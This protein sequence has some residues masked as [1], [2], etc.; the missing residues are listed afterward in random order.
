MGKGKGNEVT[1]GF[2]YK[3]WT[4]LRFKDEFGNSRCDCPPC[5][6]KRKKLKDKLDMKEYLKKLKGENYFDPK[7]IPKLKKIEQKIN[8]MQIPKKWT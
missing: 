3:K 8:A 7:N 1:P 6:D 2:S 4:K 5:K